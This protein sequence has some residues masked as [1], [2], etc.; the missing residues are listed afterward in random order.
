[1]LTLN[2]LKF[3]GKITE[4]KSPQSWKIGEI[5]SSREFDISITSNEMQAIKASFKISVT[6]EKLNF[7]NELH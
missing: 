4:L 7:F 1:M 5:I 3:G 2:S 6:P